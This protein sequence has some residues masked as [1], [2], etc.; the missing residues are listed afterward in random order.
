MTIPLPPITKVRCHL[1]GAT[2]STRV[3]AKK[4]WVGLRRHAWRC[5]RGC[6]A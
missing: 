4:V 1:C 6:A 3:D 2:L 5:L